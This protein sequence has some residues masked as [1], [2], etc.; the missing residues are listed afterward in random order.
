[1]GWLAWD[2][3]S[4]ICVRFAVLLNPKFG[5]PSFHLACFNCVPAIESEEII[6]KKRERILDVSHSFPQRT[7]CNAAYTHWFLCF[8]LVFFPDFADLFFI[9]F[10][11]ILFHSTYFYW[12]T[13]FGF[14]CIS[15]TAV[16]N[17]F[18]FTSCCV[19]VCV[20]FFSN[21]DNCAM[22]CGEWEH[23]RTSCSLFPGRFVNW[24]WNPKNFLVARHVPPGVGDPMQ[25]CWQ[26]CCLSSA[27][28]VQSDSNGT[29]LVFYFC[30]LADG[31]K[32]SCYWSSSFFAPVPARSLIILV[33]S[34][35]W[36]SIYVPNAKKLYLNIL[37]TFA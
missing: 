37:V 12:L 27:W 16:F 23:V 14:F 22:D 30:K 32:F 4:Q 15:A 24:E 6:K 17:V 25:G 19:C 8:H 18:L 10:L 21:I 36:C 20:C 9:L 35:S 1:M 5:V 34:T 31:G 33:S 2:Q 7:F 26:P 28:S 29:L 13:C 3:L 11:F